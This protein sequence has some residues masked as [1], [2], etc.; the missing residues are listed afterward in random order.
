LGFIALVIATIL[1]DVPRS[2]FGQSYGLYY[3]LIGILLNAP[4]FLFLGIV[5]GYLYQRLYESAS[6]HV[7]G[8]ELS[9]CS[10]SE[11]EKK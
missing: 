2:S 6:A 3:I 10:H 8:L 1:I 11:G 9:D 5:I 4:R 7:L